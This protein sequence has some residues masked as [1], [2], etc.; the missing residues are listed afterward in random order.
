MGRQSSRIYF[1]GKDH[2]DIYF[3]GHYHD[4]MYIGSQ[5]VWEK[6]KSEI[7]W[8]GYENSG[9]YGFVKY[10]GSIFLY[11]DDNGNLY[12]SNDAITWNVTSSPYE[13]N[14]I[15]H[16]PYLMEGNGKF[17]CGKKYR[18]YYASGYRTGYQIAISS[19]GVNWE[20]INKINVIL[21]SGSIQEYSIDNTDGFVP[22][23]DRVMYANGKYFTSSYGFINN[24]IAYSEN[25]VDWYRF[26]INIDDIGVS[27]IEAVSYIDGYYYFGVSTASGSYVVRTQNMSSYEIVFTGTSARNIWNISKFGNGII[28]HYINDI[29]YSDDGSVFEK[30]GTTFPQSGP[31]ANNTVRANVFLNSNEYVMINADAQYINEYTDISSYKQILISDILEYSPATSRISV[32]LNGKRLYVFLNQETKV[33][34]LIGTMEG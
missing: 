20:P 18:Y 19:N 3:Q 26:E 21:S 29:Y 17:I 27:S 30:I 33:I 28:I 22:Y 5:L 10:N 8:V 34:S 12:T 6:L 24:S 16:S 32:I 15:L 2:K 31:G 1:Q 7:S 25:L 9:T 11:I 14:Y 23:F 4:K 13:S